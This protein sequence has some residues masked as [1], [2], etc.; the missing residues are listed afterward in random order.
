MKSNK[1]IKITESQ[2]KRLVSEQADEKG[3]INYNMFIDDYGTLNLS[4]RKTD[5][6]PDLSNTTATSIVANY[7]RLKTLPLAEHL[8]QSLE[9]LTLI[10]ND[11]TEVDMKGYRN[12]PNLFIINLKENPIQWINWEEIENM[13]ELGRVIGVGD[14][15]N[16]DVNIANQYRDDPDNRLMID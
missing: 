2:Y 10:N 1:K 15:D 12:L 7:C 8:P 14:A 3:S 13:P 5:T 16:F 9:D 4:Y 6:L 11:I